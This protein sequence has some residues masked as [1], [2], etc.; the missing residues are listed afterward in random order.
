M[1]YRYLFALG[2][3]LLGCVGVLVA[4]AGPPLL[5]AFLCTLALLAFGLLIVAEGVD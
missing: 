1:I 3:F 4:L 2:S 5:G